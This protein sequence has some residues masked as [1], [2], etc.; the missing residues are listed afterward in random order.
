MMYIRFTLAPLL[1]LVLTLV[2]TPAISCSTCLCGDPTLTTMGAE[3]P[4]TGRLRFSVDYLDRSEVSG[5]SGID[6]T[7]LDEQRTTLGISYWP[8]ERWA[9]GIRIPFTSKQL[10]QSNLSQQSTDAIGDVDVDVRYYLWQDQPHRPRHLIG[11]QGGL[12]IPLADEE[13]QAGVALDPD[14]QPGGGLWLASAG[15]WHGFFNFPWMVYSSAQLNIGLDEGYGEFDYGSSLKLSSTLQYAINYSVALKLG[16]DLRWSGRN[17]YAGIREDNSGGFIAFV[18][19][20][21][22][23]TLAPDLI[24]NTGI[25]YPAIDNLNG[26]QEEKTLYRIGLTYDF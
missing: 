15:I 9:V 5:I 4:Y 11:L 13:T 2:S 8:A 26:E 16:A 21:I 19:P 22:V 3:K 12:R 23:L 17:S 1:A 10:T 7:Q 25:Q 24:L 18:S 14:I 6:R 20:G